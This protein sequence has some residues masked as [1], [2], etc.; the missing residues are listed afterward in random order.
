MFKITILLLFVF[1]VSASQAKPSK[2]FVFSVKD[3]RTHYRVKK[4]KNVLSYEGQSFSRKFEIKKCNE[5]LVND[6]LDRNNRFKSRGNLVL[7]EKSPG[8]Q[9]SSEE[10][11]KN[12]P[13]SSYYGKFLRDLPREILRLAI[14]EQSLCLKK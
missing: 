6:F 5:A 10:E 3:G 7:P 12:F 11:S 1:Q 13:S 9:Y 4:E 14:K 2:D 8:I